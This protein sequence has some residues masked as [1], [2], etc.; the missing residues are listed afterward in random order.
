MQAATPADSAVSLVFKQADAGLAHFALL[1]RTG[2]TEEL[3]LVVTIGSPKAL[4]I[5]QNPL[6][7]VERRAEDRLVPS[8]EDAPR[9]GSIRSGSSPDFRTAQRALS[10]SPQ[11]IP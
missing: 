4:P 1:Q 2:V 9:S 7:L 11:P 6:D 5:E 3:D 8:G 10:A